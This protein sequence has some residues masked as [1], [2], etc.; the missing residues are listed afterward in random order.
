MS[1]Y[2]SNI[3][4]SLI[5][6]TI[7]KLLKKIHNTKVIKTMTEYTISDIDFKTRLDNY[8]DD[9]IEIWKRYVNINNNTE[10]NS[11][12]NN[13]NTNNGSQLIFTD[14]F[15]VNNLSIIILLSLLSFIMAL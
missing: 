6:N 3:D 5:D 8:V 10:T 12:T 11:N 7:M 9:I 2:F 15:L 14:C 13:V 1:H 4:S